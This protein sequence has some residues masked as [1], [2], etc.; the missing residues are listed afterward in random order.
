[1]FS[2][3]YVRHSVASAARN[4]GAL[5]ALLKGED[6]GAAVY[7]GRFRSW[8][9][10]REEYLG[11]PKETLGFKIFLNSQDMSHVSASIATSGWFSLPTTCLLLA[12]L[13]PGMRVADVG[14]NLGY[15]SLLAARA[16]GERG[17]VWSFEPEPL[18]FRLLEMSV[19]AN[20][21]RQV[22]AFQLAL[23]DR[24]GT[25]TLF[26]APESEPNAH[27]LTQDRGVG[28]ID[29]PCSSLDEF[30]LE[31]GEGRLDVLKVHVHGDEPVVLRGA[32]EVLRDSRPMVITR[33]GS[34]EWDGSGG[35]LDDLFSWYDVYEVVASP[36]LIRPISRAALC[37]R[38]QA[39]IFLAPKGARV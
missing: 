19:A 11:E 1:M 36:T 17:R 26:L 32:R 13:K 38:S 6:A 22:E 24:R 39:G 5:L 28:H 18:N 10:H 12:V 3:A 34:A 16:V 23:S 9:R 8:Q 15:Y 14:A 25:E 31:K 4:P 29:V 33:F 2:W 20:G 37:G 35:L 27:T 7:E 30:W 21:Y